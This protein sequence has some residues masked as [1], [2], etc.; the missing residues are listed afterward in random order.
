MNIPFT[1][2]GIIMVLTTAIHLF[3]GGPEYHAVYQSTLPTAH[4]ASMAAVLWHA[5]TVNLMVFAGAYFWLARHP[6]LPLFVALTAMQI[7][8]AGL[9]LFYGLTMLGTPW[10]MPQWVIFLVTPLIS[11]AAVRRPAFLRTS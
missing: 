9:F 4:L 10:P 8:W 2:A 3:A 5:V 6:S 1:V 11:L 7:G